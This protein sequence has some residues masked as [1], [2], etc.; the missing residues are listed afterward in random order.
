MNLEV[1]NRLKAQIKLAEAMLRLDAINKE[2][3]QYDFRSLQKSAS[4]GREKDT[5]LKVAALIRQ[6]ELEKKAFVAAMGNMLRQGANAIGQGVSSAANYLGQRGLSGAVRDA[7]NAVGDGIETIENLPGQ[8]NNNYLRP[9]YRQG[10]Q[11]YHNVASPIRNAGAAVQGFGQGL[12][13]GAQSMAN[14]PGAMA[15][16]VYKGFTGGLAGSDKAGFDAAM[17]QGGAQVGLGGSALAGG[18]KNFTQRSLG[19]LPQ[20][21]GYSSFQMPANVLNQLGKS[22]PQMLGTNFA[23][24]Q[25]KGQTPGK[26][27]TSGV[28]NQLGSSVGNMMG[29]GTKL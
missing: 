19:K 23:G 2:L 10:Q 24:M 13:Q 8:I 17:P 5:R 11:M 16:T 25:A 21:Q 6:R 9:M 29:S 4:F 27:L 18:L 28:F 20:S 1:T 7:G 14:I 22:M 12:A 26:G 3:A 15:N